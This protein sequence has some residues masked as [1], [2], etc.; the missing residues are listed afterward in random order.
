MPP[1]DL[2]ALLAEQVAY[3][4]EVAVDYDDHSLP[5]WEGAGRQLSAALD[6][7]APTGDVLELACGTGNWTA[8][9]LR[10]A[11]SVT[12]VDS[13]PEMLAIAAGRVR[14]D[15]RAR[16]VEADVFSWRADRRYDVVVFGFWLSHVPMERFAEFWELIDA[17]LKPGGRVFF[18]DDAFRTADELID[19]EESST[20]ER[21]LGDG[22]RHRIVKVPHAA[23]DLEERLRQLGWD[24]AV[25]QTSGPFYWGAG[26]RSP[27]ASA[28]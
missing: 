14:H 28:S 3:Y 16:F 8:Q 2:D 20:I 26:G 17:A 11:T 5:G 7:F 24:I 25:P 9:I 6:A 23:P 12:A 13:S 15:D 1:N 27:T 18:A 19:G 4:R 21:R 22:T 10:H